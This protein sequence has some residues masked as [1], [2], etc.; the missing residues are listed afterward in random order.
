MCGDINQREINIY[1]Y[2][3]DYI[4]CEVQNYVGI[5]AYKAYFV[6]CFV[7]GK[8]HKLC[9]ILINNRNIKFHAFRVFH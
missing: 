4:W 9:E 3:F 2:I 5:S 7:L 6:F 8:S 1:I